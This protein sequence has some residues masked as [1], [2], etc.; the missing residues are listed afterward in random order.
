[1][2]VRKKSLFLRKQR[3]KIDRFD[4]PE[5]EKG[6]KGEERTGSAGG[7]RA[8]WKVSSFQKRDQPEQQ[9]YLSYPVSLYPI[10]FKRTK[11]SI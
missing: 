3:K 5:T 2:E 6:E 8:I 9:T 10:L 11:I 4:Y 1:M 7:S